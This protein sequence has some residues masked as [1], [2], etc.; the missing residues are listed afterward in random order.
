ME[1]MGLTKIFNT[2]SWNQTGL[3]VASIGSLIKSQPL[4]VPPWVV[5]E[6]LDSTRFIRSNS[7]LAESWWKQKNEKCQWSKI[8]QT[9][10]ISSS[11]IMEPSEHQF[12]SLSTLKKSCEFHLG[13]NSSFTTDISFLGVNINWLFII[14]GL[15]FSVNMFH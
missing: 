1:V 13:P 4:T 3:L 14:R 7:R 5:I 8:A 6:W 15:I 12:P 10:L 9:E 2:W 11:L